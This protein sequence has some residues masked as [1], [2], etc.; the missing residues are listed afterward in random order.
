MSADSLESAVAP[1]IFDAVLDPTLLFSL[2]LANLMSPRLWALRGQ[3]MS[4]AG[5]PQGNDQVIP[6]IQHFIDHHFEHITPVRVVE[7]NGV[8]DVDTEGK[9]LGVEAVEYAIA[10]ILSTYTWRMDHGTLEKGVL[11]FELIEQRKFPAYVYATIDEAW[12][13][14]RLLHR[15]KHKPLGLTCCLDEAAIFAALVLSL[16]S[17]SF[18]EI[19]F[20]GSPAHYTVLVWTAGEPWWFYGKHDLITAASWSQLVTERYDGDAQ[21]A[22]DDRLPN[23]DRII[24]EEGTYTFANGETSIDEV[25]LAALAEKLDGFF[26]LRTAQLDAALRQTRQ[27]LAPAGLAVTLHGIANAS[28][29]EDVEA[30]LRRAAL[31]DGNRAALRALYAFRALEVP[32]LQVYLRSARRGVS[33]DALSAT[34]ETVDDAIAAVAAIGGS[35]SIF[36]DRDRIAMPDETIRLA[37]GSDRDKALLLHVLLERVLARQDPAE[38]AVRTVL[39]E[40][41]SYV[42]SAGLCFD[43]LRMAEVAEI[44]GSNRRL[45]DGDQA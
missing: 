32:D 41:G 11:P 23:F 40:S 39:T 4:M 5:N 45:I 38:A 9:R 1:N 2:V 36:E 15:R 33:V 22:F 7:M 29:A 31:K 14:R 30:R 13:S 21:S 25:R 17:G 37:T 42:T 18:D 26:G 28:G 3:V 27:P 35:Q 6:R 24:T 20:I 44:E 16:P 19:V 34:M 8:F 10:E 12:A 43:T